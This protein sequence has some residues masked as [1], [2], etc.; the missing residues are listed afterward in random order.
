ME[1]TPDIKEF[2][3]QM[4]KQMFELLELAYSYDVDV[5]EI[6]S[7]VV[8]EVL[9]TIQSSSDTPQLTVMA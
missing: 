3:A 7:M 8:E 9:P 1:T 4:A 6:A 5:G 2:Q